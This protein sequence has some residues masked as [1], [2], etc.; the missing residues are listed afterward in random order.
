MADPN[1][2]RFHEDPALFR[3][4]INFTAAETAFLPALIEKDYFCTVLLA[5]VTPANNAG[6]VFKGGTCLAKVHFGF[7]RLSEDLDFGISVPITAKRKQRQT[8][9]ATAK[10][11]ISDA[12]TSEI[13]FG[14][15]YVVLCVIN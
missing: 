7:H 6:L 15:V 11:A 5:Q 3:E 13:C 8:A 2:I 9:A 10:T 14:F 12:V 1:A 4:A